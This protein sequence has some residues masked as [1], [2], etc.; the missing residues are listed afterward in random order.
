MFTMCIELALIYAVLIYKVYAWVDQI[1]AG[2][3]VTVNYVC[4]K[5][6]D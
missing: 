2:S 1:V 4:V 5:W 3:N 6:T